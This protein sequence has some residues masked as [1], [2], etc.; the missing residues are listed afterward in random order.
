MCNIIA[1]LYQQEHDGSALQVNCNRDPLTKG[2]GCGKS[3]HTIASS[4]LTE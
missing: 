2:Q 4:D 3:F 1:Y